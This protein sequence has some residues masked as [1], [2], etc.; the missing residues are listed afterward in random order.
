MELELV[1][2]EAFDAASAQS[3]KE[4]TPA[5]TGRERRAGDRRVMAE[6]RGMI[7]FEAKPDRRSGQDRRT[8]RQLWQGRDKL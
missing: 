8:A 5:Y 3:P 1:P 2:K 7:R 6:R 4:N